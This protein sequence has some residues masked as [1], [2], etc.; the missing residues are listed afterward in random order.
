MKATIFIFFV[1]LIV[2]KAQLDSFTHKTCAEYDP[3]QNSGN[4]KPAY[5]KDFC[6]TLSYDTNNKKCCFFKYKGEDGYNYYHCLEL[7]NSEYLD[8]NNKIKSL[9]YNVKSLECDSSSYLYGSFLLFLIFL[10]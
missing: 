9:N 5:S 1:I 10:F 4:A 8:I 6:R 2:I 3:I 7:Y